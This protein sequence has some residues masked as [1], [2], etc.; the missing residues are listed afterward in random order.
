MSHEE[1][2]PDC[3]GAIKKEVSRAAESR[4]R[5]NPDWKRLLRTQVETGTEPKYV[6]EHEPKRHMRT[7]YHPSMET[8]PEKLRLHR[9]LN[10]L[11][12]HP[13]SLQRIVAESEEAERI[14]Q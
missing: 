3:G 10:Y 11:V 14:F 2:C 9:Q 8:D 6:R 1:L 7:H 5:E 13:E 4:I 12:E